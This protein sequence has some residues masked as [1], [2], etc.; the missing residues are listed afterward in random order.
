MQ[1]FAV[2]HFA[3]LLSIERLAAGSMTSGTDLGLQQPACTIAYGRKRQLR[4]M[5]SAAQVSTLE[6]QLV[7]HLEV[8]EAIAWLAEHRLKVLGL[9]RRLPLPTVT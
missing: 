1:S 7:R 9:H 6:R 8:P 2:N 4:R 5:T 3:K